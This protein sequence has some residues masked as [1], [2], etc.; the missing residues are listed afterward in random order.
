MLTRNRG[1]HAPLRYG[2]PAM[3][4][5]DFDPRS[6]WDRRLKRN[7][8]LHGVGFSTLSRSYNRWLYRVRRVVFHRLLRKLDVNLAT[9]KVLDVGPGIGFYVNLWQRNGVSDITGV[10]IADSAVARLRKRYPTA[11]FEQADI[12]DDVS[13]LGADYDIVD[14]FDILFHIVDDDRYE[15]AMKNIYRM[16]KPGGWFVFSDNFV[17]S[18]TVRTR[19]HVSRSIDD[20]SDAVRKAGFQILE[21]RPMFVLMNWPVDRRGALQQVL[22]RKIVPALKHERGGNVLGAAMTPFELVLTK[23]RKESPT[24]EIMICRKPA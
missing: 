8:N 19:N 9:A 3:S 22:W 4:A 6:Y 10:D 5:T 23:V 16:L 18:E 20:I 12:S 1:G 2:L 24:T 14:A 13:H 7:F 21:R 11:R 17:H 15:A